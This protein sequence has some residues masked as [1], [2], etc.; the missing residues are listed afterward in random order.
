MDIISSIAIV[1]AVGVTYFFIKLV[2]NPVLRILLDIVVFMVGVYLLQH[3]L[4]FDINKML[5]PFGISFNP[6]NW[7]SHLDWIFKPVNYC[8]NLVSNFL[9]NI[10][11][12]IHK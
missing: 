9:K 5:A 11:P 4:G 3:Y 12:N 6:N 1:L 7:G 2:V 8:I 10:W